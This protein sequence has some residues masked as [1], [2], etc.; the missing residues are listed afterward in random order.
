M[1][2]QLYSQLAKIDIEHWFFVYRARLVEL[3]F[4]RFSFEK[5]KDGLD[6]GC[7]TG[8][9]SKFLNNYCENV[10]PLS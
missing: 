2:A 4:E 1:K 3:F 9:N 8:G 10:A 5:A 6:L 7:G